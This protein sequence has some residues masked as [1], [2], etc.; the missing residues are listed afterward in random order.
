LERQKVLTVLN[1]IDLQ[2]NQIKDRII[3]HMIP[4]KT[5]DK[6]SLDQMDRFLT[7][8]SLRKKTISLIFN[9][10]EN[11]F[12]IDDNNSNSDSLEDE[13]NKTYNTFLR[14]LLMTLSDYYIILLN[15]E[16]NYSSLKSSDETRKIHE[17]SFWSL[18]SATGQYIDNIINL[19]KED[20]FG[21][22]FQHENLKSII[23]SISD[24]LSS[25]FIDLKEYP[26]LTYEKEVINY[27]INILL[28]FN[29]E[30]VIILKNNENIKEIIKFLSTLFK[31]FK[32]TF[33]KIDEK[34]LLQIPYKD[35]YRVFDLENSFFQVIIETTN[36][37]YNEDLNRLVKYENLSQ[38]LSKSLV[39][40]QSFLEK[41]EK[42][43]HLDILNIPV[44][45]WVELCDIVHQ[46]LESSTKIKE[47]LDE[48]NARLKHMV[49][50]I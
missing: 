42:E 6:G 39:I 36:S 30:K 23:K 38:N 20:S 27:F 43:I 3:S 31:L 45:S 50:C 49:I 32:K 14:N 41:Y 34:F 25:S 15:I 28:S 22:K 18:V 13:N 19:I 9:I 16:V 47:D 12:L 5:F 44:P 11:D 40:V 37:M 46:E 24:C 17:A 35:S 7:V 33:K 29:N 26:I 4:K 2:K 21:V 1:N 10:I 8:I 48:A